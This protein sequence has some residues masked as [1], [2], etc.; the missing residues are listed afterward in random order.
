MLFQDLELFFFLH[1]TA[2]ICG[3]GALND[4]ATTNIGRTGTRPWELVTFGSWKVCYHF[5]L[6]CKWEWGGGILA[7]AATEMW[8]VKHWNRLELN[9]L[10]CSL[11]YYNDY[12]F[13]LFVF[14]SE[15]Y[16]IQISDWCILSQ[17]CWL[18]MFADLS[19]SLLFFFQLHLFDWIPETLQI[20]QTH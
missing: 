10:A 8:Q 19:A 9:G 1:R 20:T 6:R 7:L 2:L 13:H 3:V 17:L 16:L 5:E 4:F 11:T 15:W 12:L 18:A 14:G